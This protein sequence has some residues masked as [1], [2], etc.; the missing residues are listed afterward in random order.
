MD[1]QDYY[2][3]L[4]VSK[5]ATPEE[6]RSA[7]RKKAREFHPDV[8]KDKVKGGYRDWETNNSSKEQNNFSLITSQQKKS[9]RR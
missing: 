3:V 7:F 9:F 6:I 2:G 5:T 1:Y 4:G 8:A